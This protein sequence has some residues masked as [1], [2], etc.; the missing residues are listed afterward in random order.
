VGLEPADV[1]ESEPVTA[2]LNLLHT[3]VETFGGSVGCAGVV[4]GE[5]LG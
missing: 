3:Q 4:V 5:D 2:A 1:E